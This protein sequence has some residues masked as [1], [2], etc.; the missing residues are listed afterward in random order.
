MT[1]HETPWANWNA[2]TPNTPNRY[3]LSGVGASL[4][5]SPVLGSQIAAT[6]ASRL[7]KNPARD[8][9]G[10]DSDSRPARILF[11]LQ[12]SMAF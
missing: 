1:L 11:W 12:G 7:G 3:A 5:Y 8:A 10:R 9:T 6:V 2:A 4:V